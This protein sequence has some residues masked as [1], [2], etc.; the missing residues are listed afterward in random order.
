MYHTHASTD[1]RRDR[2]KS[3]VFSFDM[4]VSNVHASTYYI[5]I[6]N[7]LILR[8]SNINLYQWYN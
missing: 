2:Y 7:K 5:F 1:L 6:N 8:D 4:V 3:V